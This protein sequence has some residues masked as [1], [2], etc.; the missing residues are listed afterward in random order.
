MQINY[1][2]NTFTNALKQLRE[3]VNIKQVNH[4][5]NCNI[6]YSDCDS[7]FQFLKQRC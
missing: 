6:K 7:E 1:Q 2:I 3:A 5:Q 4:D